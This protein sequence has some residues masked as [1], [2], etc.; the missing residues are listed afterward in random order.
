MAPEVGLDLGYGFPADVYSFGILLWEICALEKPF[1]D[2]KPSKV[3][4]KAVFEGGERPAIKKRWPTSLGKLMI[5]CWSALPN[6]R[7]S[8]FDVKALLTKVNVAGEKK[9]FL[10]NSRSMFTM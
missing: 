10:K 8:M 4:D 3:F 5:S 7:P 1:S 2:M 9:T 6:D